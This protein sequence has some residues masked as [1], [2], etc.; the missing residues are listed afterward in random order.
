LAGYIGSPRLATASDGAQLQQYR[1]AHDTALAIAILDGVLDEREIP[2]YAKLMLNDK[3]LAT[4]LNRSSRN[5]LEIE[6][7]Q[8]DLMKKKGIE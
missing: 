1:S 7:K 6:R 5:D 8:R 3:T 4:E 2:R